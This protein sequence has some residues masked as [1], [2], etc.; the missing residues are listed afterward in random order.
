MRD[1]LIA[2]HGAHLKTADRHVRTF[3][4]RRTR[5][6]MEQRGLI[7]Q[8][9]KGMWK[10]DELGRRAAAGEWL[11]LGDGRYERVL[12]DGRS[13]TVSQVI[14][15]V[16]WRWAVLSRQGAITSQGHGF[17]SAEAARRAADERYPRA[18]EPEPVPVG[19]GGDAA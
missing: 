16:S 12:A 3:V 5:V 9:P 18:D 7:T 17:A 2:L 6:G 19:G 13:L 4:D 10:L 15:R 8:T 1:A 14:G 11:A